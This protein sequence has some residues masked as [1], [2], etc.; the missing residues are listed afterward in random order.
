M[1][2]APVMAWKVSSL[3]CLITRLIAAH[4]PARLD[5]SHLCHSRGKR[6][7]TFVYMAGVADTPNRMRV[8]IF[9]TGSCHLASWEPFS[10]SQETLVMDNTRVFR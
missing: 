9:T 3:P 4:M 6:F 8:I 10:G 2:D 5:T 7:S 1:K